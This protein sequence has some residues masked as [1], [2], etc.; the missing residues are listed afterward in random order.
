[1]VC[2]IGEALALTW[3]D[4]DFEKNVI[5][6]NH[7]VA[8]TVKSNGHYGQYIKRPKSDPTYE[9]IKRSIASLEGVMF[10]DYTD[11]PIKWA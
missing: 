8:Y 1:M 2:R 3:E 6:I 4:V 5:N 10:Y 11:N 9:G 7:S